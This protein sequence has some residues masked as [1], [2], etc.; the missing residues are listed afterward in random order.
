MPTTRCPQLDGSGGGIYDAEYDGEDDDADAD[1]DYSGYDDNDDED[2]Y[3]NND[4]GITDLVSTAARSGGF[5][6]ARVLFGWVLTMS[7]LI[8]PINL[9]SMAK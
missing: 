3:T 5:G 9:K 7:R 8:L 2:G 1:A 6:R 4:V